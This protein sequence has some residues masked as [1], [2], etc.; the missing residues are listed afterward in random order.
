MAADDFGCH[1]TEGSDAGLHEATLVELSAEAEVGDLDVDVLVEENV[2]QLQVAVDDALGV[3]VRDAEDELAKDAAGLV[4][5]EAVQ[6]LL[7]E[8]VEQFAAGAK[9]GNEVDGRLGRDEFEQRE[10]VRVPQPPVVVDLA[11]QERQ[12][13]RRIRGRVLRGPIR[14][15]AVSLGCKG[16]HGDREGGPAHG[17]QAFRDLLDRDPRPGETVHSEPDFAERA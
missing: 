8:V 12:R 5:V 9:F 16:R 4:E 13:R 14:A 11:G 10:D 2:L 7:D 6:V 3:E 1:V 15:G 17:R